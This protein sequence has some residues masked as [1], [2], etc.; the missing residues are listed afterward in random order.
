MR[1]K[2][3]HLVVLVAAVAVA[4]VAI[5]GVLAHR[6]GPRADG[7]AATPLPAP[8]TTATAPVAKTS[9][10]VAKTPSSTP[11]KNPTAT[12]SVTPRGPAFSGPVKVDFK[13]SKLPR[14]RSPQMPYLV[15][16]EV[17]GGAGQPITIPGSAYVQ[18]IS[19]LGD[20]VFAIVT[21]GE[22]TE[23]LKVGYPGAPVRTPDVTSVVT[24]DDE[25][26]AAYAASRR[27]SGGGA[28][29]GGTVYAQTAADTQVHKLS[30]PKAWDIRVLGYTNG[31]VYFRWSDSDGAT[32][33]RLSTWTPG[34]SEV[35]LIKTV[36]SPTALTSDGRIAA[37][38]NISQ[39]FG[40]CSNLTEIATGKRLWRTCENQVVAFTPDG[41]IAVGAPASQD[42]YADLQASALD[43]KTGALLREWTGPAFKKTV[44]EDDQ[45]FLIQADDGPETKAAIVR[46]TV[47]TGACELAVPPT[48]GQ[49]LL[50][51]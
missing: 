45:H 41:T 27:G 8:S 40:S 17:R 42:G 14:G 6:Q 1:P 28:V 25:T 15:G 36:P 16:R 9:T 24:T 33:W 34:S 12:P 23:L 29:Q 11:P 38:R 47:T 39:D 51:R 30:L 19:R 43:A 50:G 31:Q 20:Q 32:S 48:T 13:L 22:G 26:A 49:V 44:A 37:S 35:T 18:E 2:N 10:P 21:K 46:C 3:A 5:G 4:A 7:N